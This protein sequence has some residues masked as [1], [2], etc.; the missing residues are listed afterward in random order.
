[1]KLWATIWATRGVAPADAGLAIASEIT[2]ASAVPHERCATTTIAGE[3]GHPEAWIRQFAHQVAV[4][5]ESPW[6]RSVQPL[7]ERS[8]SFV[9]ESR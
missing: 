6:R 2:D 4:S 1:M 8:T 3:T 9:F 5:A 7:L